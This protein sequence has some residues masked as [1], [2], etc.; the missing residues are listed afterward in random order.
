LRGYLS[1][2]RCRF[3]Y[4]LADATATHYLAVAA[5]GAV[6]VA[7][8]AVAA[9][10]ARVPSHVVLFAMMYYYY[11]HLSHSVSCIYNC[12]KCAILV[13]ELSV[14]TVEQKYLSCVL[15]VLTE[16]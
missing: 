4:G 10:A 6:A 1:G 8:A 2:A 3:A 11:R 13:A 7:V 9:A 5:A 16:T 12:Y 15:N 14:Y